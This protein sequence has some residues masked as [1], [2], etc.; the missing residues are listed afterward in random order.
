MRKIFKHAVGLLVAYFV[1][2]TAAFVGMSSSRGESA[3]WDLY[4]SYFTM[5]WTFHAGELPLFIWLFSVVAFVPLAALVIF[6]LW[7]CGRAKQ[8]DA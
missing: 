4:W 1:A 7:M 5:A 8:H 3:P 2:W 6:A